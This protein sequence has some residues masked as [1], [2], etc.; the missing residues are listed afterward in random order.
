VR[1]GWTL[2]DPWPASGSELVSE[3]TVNGWDCGIPA[4]ADG[5]SFG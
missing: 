3:D 2:W 5:A 4:T 1:A